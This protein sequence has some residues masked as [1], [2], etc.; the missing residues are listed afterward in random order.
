MDAW[1][2]RVEPLCRL[3]RRFT[4]TTR[5]RFLTSSAAAAGSFVLSPLAVGCAG[6]Q[7]AERTAADGDE[8]VVLGLHPSASLDV[9]EDA[10]TRT[11]EAV[12]FSWLRPGDS[13]FIKVACN[14]RNVHPAVTSP[15]AIRAMVKALRDRGA[16]RVLVG[17]Q[18]GVASVRLTPDGQRFSSTERVMASN[19]LLAAIEDSGAE[20]HFFDDQG[21]D[22]GYVQADFDLPGSSW[23][24]P[25]HIARVVTEVDHLVYLP[26]ISSHL[27]TG[28]T[29]G[30]KIAVGWL[31]DDSRH[32]LHWDAADIF[33]KYTEV[34]YCRQIRSRLRLVVSYA[35]AIMAYGGPDEGTVVDADPRV[36]I[37]SSSLA[38]HDVAS[39]SLL[40]HAQEHLPMSRFT[41]GLPYGPWANVTNG[42]LTTFVQATTGLLWTSGAGVLPTSYVPHSYGEGVESDRC[43]IKA[44]ELL[45]GVPRAIEVR[46]VGTPPDPALAAVFEAHGRLALRA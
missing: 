10:I 43:L 40:N 25:A 19:G 33:E 11:L 18:S 16:G 44:Y 5:R 13:V 8:G 34:N 41:G 38:H 39:V 14:S 31:R 2:S 42:M 37:A 1:R 28:Y 32:D 7:L 24:R 22:A 27:M 3:P 36:V 12:D 9:E 46:V 15:T 21:F 23:T 45:G 29:A 4:V 30:H 6:P 26:R 35:D 20:P 17:D